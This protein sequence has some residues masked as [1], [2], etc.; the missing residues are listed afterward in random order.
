MDRPNYGAT[1]VYRFPADTTIFGPAQIEARIDQDPIISQQISLWDQA[2]SSVIRGNLIVVPLGDSLI[3]LQP[4]YLQST[5]S[6]F[7]EF[8]R[9]IVASPHSVVWAPT[10][11]DAI[12]LLVAADAR[13]GEPGASPT[14]T[15]TPEPGSS[16]TPAPTIDPGAPL[17]TDLAG[18]ID[19]ANVHFALAQDALRDGDFARYGA[20]I[21]LVEAALER[22]DE[23]APGLIP[24]PGA[25]PAP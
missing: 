18:L 16:P 6:S 15:P 24:S 5:S 1:R 14:P 20:E 9:I 7:P 21:D 22:L 12:G 11:G 10:L 8:R 17:P 25:S 23:L 2:G 19:Y 4:V 13:G 3:Y